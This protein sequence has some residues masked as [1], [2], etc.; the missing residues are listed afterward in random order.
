MCSCQLKVAC[1]CGGELLGPVRLR[2]FQTGEGSRPPLVLVKEK[3]RCFYTILSL[4]CIVV[5]GNILPTGDQEESCWFCKESLVEHSRSCRRFF[6][7]ALKRCH[8][9]CSPFQNKAHCSVVQQFLAHYPFS[10]RYVSVHP[11]ISINT[12]DLPMFCHH[13]EGVVFIVGVAETLW[14]D[15]HPPSAVFFQLCGVNVWADL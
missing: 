8:F 12:M 4:K 15:A 9:L 1:A 2:C 10:H 11:Y 6:S 13:S 3:N 5:N 14:P 7:L